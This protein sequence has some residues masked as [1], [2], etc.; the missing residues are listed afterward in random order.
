MPSAPVVLEGGDCCGSIGWPASRATGPD[1]P[2]TA[3]AKELTAWPAAPELTVDPLTGSF[4]GTSRAGTPMRNSPCSPL[5]T[6]HWPPP[7]RDA[8][9]GH[10]RRIRAGDRPALVALSPAQDCEPVREVFP[11][12]PLVRMFRY[13]REAA[14]EA[15]RKQRTG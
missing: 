6:D 1:A 3:E 10:V 4:P 11:S 13:I 2:T 5:T 12:E 8:V 7:D 9:R 15:A 14:D